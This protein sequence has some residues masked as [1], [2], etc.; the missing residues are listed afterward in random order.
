M[1]ERP[2]TLPGPQGQALRGILCLPNG[3]GPFPAVACFHGLTLTHAI[4]ESVA[5]GLADAGVASL[6]LNFRGH[7]DSDGELDEQGFED[8]IADVQAGVEALVG[9]A[10][11]DPK[12]LGILGFSMGAA[13]C[14]LAAQRLGE[15]VKALALW[16]PLLKTSQWQ[17]ARFKAYGG[18][19]GGKVRLWDDILVSER[20]FSEA[21]ASDP[22][23]AA[24]AF[25]GPALFVHGGRDNN[26][27]QL[28][29]EEA[30][31]ERICSGLETW[32]AFV[33]LSG[34]LFR[35]DAERATRDRLTAEFFGAFL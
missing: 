21:V 25:P 33:P 34:H 16:A 28:A 3:A 10:E 14:A 19:Q 20:L 31:A 17:E 24:A 2:L 27:P 9:L 1:P 15:R 18:R 22:Y 30:V 32:H 26:H 6:R 8:Q 7:G 12:R 11:A 29:T 4:F 35:H 23:A 5:P 13:A